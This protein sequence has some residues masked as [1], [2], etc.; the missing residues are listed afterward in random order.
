MNNP[1]SPITNKSGTVKTAAFLSKDIV[2]LYRQQ[3]G[4]DVAAF[5]PTEGS[6]Y[7]Y[8]CNETGYRFYYPQGMDG[9]GAFYETLQQK[10]GDGYYHDWKFEYQLAFDTVQNGDKVLDIGCG[11]GNF[12]TRATEKAAEVCGLELNK[13]AAAVCR[14]KGL[15]VQDELIGEHAAK[16]EGYYDVVCMFQVLEHIY[17][18]KI[19]LQDAIRALKKGGKLVIGVPNNEPYFLGYDKYCTLNLP[20]HHMGLWNRE[21]F[22]NLA[23]LFNLSIQQVVYDVK[24]SIKTQ[25][26]LHAKYL[27]NIKSIG[28]NHTTIEKIKMLM[29]GVITFPLAV[30]K[31]ITTGIN[32]SHIAVVFTKL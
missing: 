16:K 28:G 20:P 19:F 7:L 12:L 25:A 6:F 11:V 29:M 17:D 5:M 32:G 3:L 10:L 31:K 26:Y 2:A 15:A 23:P 8:R 4:M 14:Q 9:D 18:I 30:I 22:E 1:L 21:V 27:L 24:G 13:K